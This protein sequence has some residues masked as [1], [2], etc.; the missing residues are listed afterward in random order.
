[1]KGGVCSV[2]SGIR[3]LMPQMLIFIL[4]LKCGQRNNLLLFSTSELL[5]LTYCRRLTIYHGDH[6]YKQCGVPDWSEGVLSVDL[7]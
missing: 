5:L 1:M 4:R 2:R 6:S 3:R 7:P